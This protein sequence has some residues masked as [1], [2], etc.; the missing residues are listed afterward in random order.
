MCPWQQTLS[1]VWFFNPML[2]GS[3]LRSSSV[4][5]Y[6]Y[7]YY[8]YY[9]YYSFQI[10]NHT[11]YYCPLTIISCPYEKMGCEIKVSTSAFR[12]RKR[13]KCARQC[14]RVLWVMLVHYCLIVCPRRIVYIVFNRICDFSF[15]YAE[16][17]HKLDDHGK[18]LSLCVNLFTFH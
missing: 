10:R 1:S 14:R 17:V 16:I 15:D 8:Y 4:Y 6:Y 9:C 7:Y 5:Y 13:R 12:E 2:V 18:V 11:E 3:F